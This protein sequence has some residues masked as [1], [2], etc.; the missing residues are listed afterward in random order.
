MNILPKCLHV[1]H[2]SSFGLQ[3]SEEDIRAYGMV[4]G[5]HM[6]SG[7][8]PCFSAETSVL[9]TT[10]PSPINWFLN[11]A[12]GVIFIRTDKPISK[13]ILYDQ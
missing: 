6:G 12:F 4:V 8:K 7:H 5:H 11:Y 1:Y 13:D 10:G 2:V 3:R 9:L